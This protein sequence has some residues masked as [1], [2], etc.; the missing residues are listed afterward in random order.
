MNTFNFQGIIQIQKQS[1]DGSN[2]MLVNDICAAHFAHNNI[3]PVMN[4]PFYG[5]DKVR[6][7]IKMLDTKNTGRIQITEDIRDSNDN[8]CEYRGYSI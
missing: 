3:H 4:H 7:S 5:T 2:A 8:F 6:E 1:N